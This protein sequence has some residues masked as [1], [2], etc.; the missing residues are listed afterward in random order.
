MNSKILALNIKKIKLKINERNSA[1]ENLNEKVIL[2]ENKLNQLN[3]I[4]QVL[5]DNLDAKAQINKA[6][7]TLSGH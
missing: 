4:K 3:A 7:K 1:L 5:L 6:F 2:S